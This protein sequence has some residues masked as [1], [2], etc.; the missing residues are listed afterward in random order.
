MKNLTVFLTISTLTILLSFVGYSQQGKTDTCYYQPPR[1]T[2]EQAQQNA[3]AIVKY[4]IALHLLGQK[5]E[6]LRIKEN[7]LFHVKAGFNSERSLYAIG[8]KTKQNEL[9]RQGRVKKR[10]KIA[11]G[12]LAIIAGAFYGFN[13]FMPTA[14][15]GIIFHVFDRVAPCCFNPFMPTAS[16]GIVDVQLDTSV[17]FRCFNPF[18]PT[19]SVGIKSVFCLYP[20]GRMFQS[21]YAH[22]ER[23]NYLHIAKPLFD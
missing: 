1:M 15:V 7:E 10:W 16:V 5:D 14:S 13:P 20:Y 17:A 9:D 19:A 3:N 21:F 12:I 23:W 18:M 8:L 22:S 4:P 11:T 6:M 2:C